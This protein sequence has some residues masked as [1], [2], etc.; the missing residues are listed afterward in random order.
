MTRFL[1]PCV[2]Y[3]TLSME[4]AY[5]VFF[6]AASCHMQRQGIG[7]FFV[8]PACKSDS[9]LKDLMDDALL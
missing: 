9:L 7:T 2:T 4:T 3:Y 1:L 8:S 5:Y 6:Y